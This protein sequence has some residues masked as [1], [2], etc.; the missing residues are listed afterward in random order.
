[1][2][3]LRSTNDNNKAFSQLNANQKKSPPDIDEIVTSFKSD[4]SDRNSLKYLITKKPTPNER[5]R[6][7]TIEI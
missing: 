2:R 3:P 5:K 7:S 1:M 6:M 4:H